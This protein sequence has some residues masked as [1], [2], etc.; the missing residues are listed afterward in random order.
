MASGER[1]IQQQRPHQV[2]T[3]HLASQQNLEELRSLITHPRAAT[4]VLWSMLSPA[5][6]A[7]DIAVMT[8]V[9]IPRPTRDARNHEFA[10]DN[11]PE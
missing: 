2:A 5:A 10:E 6:A 9:R 1:K 8:R 4:S 3:S 7:G 11:I